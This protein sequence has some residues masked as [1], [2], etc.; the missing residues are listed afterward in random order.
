MNVYEIA[1]K[2]AALRRLLD[3]AIE[4]VC[5][6]QGSI[7]LLSEDGKSL[8]FVVSRSPVADKLRQIEQPMGK[9]I[10]GLAVALQ[11]PMIVNETGRSTAFDPSVDAKTGTKTKSIMVIPLVT[12]QQ[13]FGA[14]TAINSTASAGFVPHD[15]EQFSEFAEKIAERLSKLPFDTPNVGT[16]G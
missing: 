2:D 1:S 4:A 11:Q 15:L 5:A 13:E 3:E 14:L 16:V 10:T 8:R 7:L 9:G 12:P 6:E